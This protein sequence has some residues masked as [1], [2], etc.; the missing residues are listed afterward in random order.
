MKSIDLHN[1]W[2]NI[3]IHALSYFVTIIVY[4]LIQNETHV[5]IRNK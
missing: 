5:N 3:P 4:I 1:I 2:L